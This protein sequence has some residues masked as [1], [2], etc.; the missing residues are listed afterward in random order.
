MV[1]TWLNDT[2]IALNRFFE[3]KHTYQL[4]IATNFSHSV[5]WNRAFCIRFSSLELYY[6]LTTVSIVYHHPQT[7]LED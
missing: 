6:G 4:Q 7:I 1:N 3:R 2:A 5:N